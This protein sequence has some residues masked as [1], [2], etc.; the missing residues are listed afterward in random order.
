M[1]LH[2]IRDKKDIKL[3]NRADTYILGNSSQHSLVGILEVENL[4]EMFARFVP[5]QKH[6]QC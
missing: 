4:K 3:P 5:V 1:P 2:L 6:F